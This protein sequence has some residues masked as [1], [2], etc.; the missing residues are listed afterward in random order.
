MTNIV[1]NTKLRCREGDLALIIRE[2]PGC[3]CNIGRV[4]TVHGPLENSGRYGPTWLIVPVNPERW[5]VYSHWRNLV[6]YHHVTLEHRIEHPDNWLLPLRPVPQE[7]I[8]FLETK[9]P[10]QGETGDHVPKSHEIDTSTVNGV[11]L[12]SRVIEFSPRLIRLRRQVAKLPV[13]GEYRDALY[14]SI[15]LYGSQIVARPEYKPEDGWDDLEALQ[16]VTLGDMLEHSLREQ[17]GKYFEGK[18]E[19]H[20]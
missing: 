12:S 8:H 20:E 3:E 4:V 16:Q 2:E 1:G 15:E 13:R 18:G 10:A 17:F 5:A 9:V 14:R 19:N 11:D 6:D 7:A